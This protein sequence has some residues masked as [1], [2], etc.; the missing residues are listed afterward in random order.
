MGWVAKVRNLGRRGG[1]DAEIEEELRAHIEMAVEDGVRAGMSEEEARRAARVRFG[2]PVTVK[3]RTVGADAALGFESLG[4]DVKIALRQLKKSPGFAV[5]AV[6]T[7]ALGIGANS[8]VFT[9]I[10][11]AMLRSL[12][13]SKPAQLVA[14]GY[15]SPDTSRFL[16]VQFWPVMNVLEHR[17][18]GVSGLAGWSGSMVTVPDDRNTLRSVG[19]DLVTGNALSMLGVRP[20][21]GRLLTPTDDVPGG[22]AGGWP[23]VLDYGFWL[24]NFHGDPNVVGRRMRISEQP[25]VV[26]GVLPPD[27]HGLYVGEPQKLYL[28]LHFLSALAASAQQ[29]PFLHP[30]NLAVLAVARLDPG[31][32]LTALN[33]ELA[34]MSPSLHSL[35]PLRVQ[36]EPVF[37]TAHLAAESVRRGFSEIAEDYGKPLLLIQAIALA[38]LLLCCVNLAGLQMARIQARE[39]E[40]AVRSALGAG[41]GRI[42][43]QCLVESM[44]LATVGCVFAA[45]LAW[46]S[47]RIIS[48][49]FTPAGSGSPIQ[50]QPDPTVLLFT[51]AF[52][53]L[54]TLLFGLTPAWL[55]GKVSPG[56]VFRGRGTTARHHLLRQRV[57]IP[58]QLALALA[59]VFCAGLFTHTLVRLRDNHE[60]F[61]PDHVMEVCAQFQALKKSPDQIMELYHSMTEALRASPDVEAASYTWV[62]PVTGFAPKLD[63]DSLAHPQDIASIAWND[64][65]DGYFSTVGTRVLAGRGFT[66][67]DRDRSTCILNEAAAGLLFGHAR[68]LGDSI[69]AKYS[70]QNGEIGA[71]TAACRVVG[72]V[73]NARYSSLRDPAPPTV[74]FPASAS[75]VG[76]GSYSN[77]LVFLIRSRNAVDA[78]SAY[79]AA[80][81]R[82]APTTAYMTFLPLSEQVDQSI[83]SE[84]LVARLSAI[85]AAVALLLS[86]IGLF[87]VL[88]LRVQQRRPEIGVRLA[89]GASRAR[90]LALVLRDA[91]VMLVAG[92][93]AGIVLIAI[94][95]GF[96]RRFLYDTSPLQVGVVLSTVLI[97][98]AVAL[99]A[100]L[101]PARRAAGVDPMEA[102]KS[103]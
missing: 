61:N 42:L 72:V 89:V 70:D 45:D 102:L 54:T 92:T 18:R 27:F 75:T 56:A 100:A 55:A 69:E 30:E 64:V 71:F 99:L 53:L 62:T 34:A 8:A 10:N 37:R 44:L 26:V 77:N 16:A 14:L 66:L 68:P 29:D 96:L 48:G 67:A 73:E 19:A 22:P 81:A 90:I 43:R 20:V 94:T 91:L 13:I 58:A 33:A 51:A 88:A 12:P 50:L 6:L 60:G 65:G 93:L 95:S 15:R 103:E 39:Q 47:V 31:M 38:V 78:I 35:T 2:N 9:V 7:L 79:R 3:E 57:F 28:P 87:G 84:R 23:V 98:A 4:R 63:V 36:H 101:V 1:V 49:F 59:L 80:L 32:S 5:T 52:A 41:R 85:F 97:L 25:A 40:F 46:A 74:Y 86:G 11:D 83:G 76:R 24:A 17:L 82:F 21:L